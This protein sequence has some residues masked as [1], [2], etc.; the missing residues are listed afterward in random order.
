MVGGSLRPGDEQCS[1]DGCSGCE[2]CAADLT[3]AAG[4][5][6]PATAYVSEGRRRRRGGGREEAMG[7]AGE[8][9]ARWR[10]RRRDGALGHGGR[11][12][13]RAWGAAGGR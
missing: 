11:G 5:A 6:E 4:L 2:G 7:G 1:W 9:E 13:D 3:V 8:E 12:E 10:R